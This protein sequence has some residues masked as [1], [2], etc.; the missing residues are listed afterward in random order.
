MF[1]L[2]HLSGIRVDIISVA[3]SL[4]HSRISSLRPEAA[5]SFYNKSSS[6]S[7]SRLHF[8]SF[9]LNSDPIGGIHLKNP[10][11]M[12]FLLLTCLFRINHLGKTKERQP[13]FQLFLV[14]PQSHFTHQTHPSLH[15][16][17]MIHVKQACSK[18]ISRAPSATRRP[19][20]YITNVAYLR[21]KTIPTLSLRGGNSTQL[22]RYANREASERRCIHLNRALEGWQA[23][24]TEPRCLF[25]LNCQ[26]YCNK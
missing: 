18:F 11:F 25:A 12:N 3:M 7:S 16:L 17:G 23:A 24:T 26:M 22:T 14:M 10:V 15:L 21:L 9:Q 8:N 20:H 4:Q 19:P 13:T 1:I 2:R 6:S 5:D